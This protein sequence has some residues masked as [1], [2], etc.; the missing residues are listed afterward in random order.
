[1]V[2]ALSFSLMRQYTS[3]GSSFTCGNC[4]KTSLNSAFTSSPKA[5]S[6]SSPARTSIRSRTAPRVQY[7]GRSG[8]GVTNFGARTSFSSFWTSL[9]FAFI[10]CAHRRSVSGRSRGGLDGTGFSKSKPDV[11]STAVHAAASMTM[12]FLS[13]KVILRMSSV[14]K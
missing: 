14:H 10:F 3:M 12:V 5:R 4:S 2:C 7:L 6:F 11:L 13:R 8:I 9:K 1:M